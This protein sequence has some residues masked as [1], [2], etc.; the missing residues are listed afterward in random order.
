MKI[1]ISG[2]TAAGKTTTANL[3]A[4]AFGWPVISWLSTMREA[5]AESDPELADIGHHTP[6]HDHIRRHDDQIDRVVDQILLERVRDTDRGV[7]DAWALPWRAHGA[8]V[9]IWIESDEPSRVRKAV[10]SRQIRGLAPDPDVRASLR[11]K[12]EFARKKFRRLYGFDIFSDRDPF[13]IIINNERLIPAATIAAADAGIRRITPVV[14]QCV[15]T[16][17]G[18]RPSVDEASAPFVVRCRKA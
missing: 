15:E 5:V 10:V 14:A 12:D 4:D 7:F 11:H 18:L 16:V 2:L 8:A 13:D 17:M 6:A 9:S 3:V 1:L